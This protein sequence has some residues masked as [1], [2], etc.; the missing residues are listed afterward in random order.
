MCGERRC[1]WR[2]DESAVLKAPNPFLPEEEIWGCPECK[3]VNTIVAVCDEPGCWA[4]T[5]CGTPTPSGYRRT[6]GKHAP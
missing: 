6:C 2:G 5:S 4:E 3:A 1:E